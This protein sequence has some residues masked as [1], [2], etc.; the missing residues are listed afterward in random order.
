[1]PALH[2]AIERRVSSARTRTARLV[3]T[4]NAS[5]GVDVYRL[6]THQPVPGPQTSAGKLLEAQKPKAVFGSDASPSDRTLRGR[7]S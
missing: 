6:S 3:Y 1:M 7:P 5:E 4:E 2:L